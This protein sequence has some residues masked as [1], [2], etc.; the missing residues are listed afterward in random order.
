M[1]E[2]KPALWVIILRCSWCHRFLPGFV[3]Y[4][5]Y[6]QNWLCHLCDT[7]ISRWIVR[8]MGWPR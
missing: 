7:E 5:T 8:Q 4:G 6:Q 2:R 3:P 1:N